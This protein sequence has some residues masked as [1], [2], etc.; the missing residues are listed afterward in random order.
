MLK[1][2]QRRTARTDSSRNFDA[3][4]KYYGISVLSKLVP[5]V[6]IYAGHHRWNWETWN[7]FSP[8]QDFRL[9]F[10]RPIFKGLFQVTPG[11]HRSSKEPPWIA[12]RCFFITVFFSNNQQCTNTKENSLQYQML[13]KDS[14]ENK[15]VY[16]VTLGQLQRARQPDSRLH[17][18]KIRAVYAMGFQERINRYAHH[19]ICAED[20]GFC[21]PNRS[22]TAINQFTPGSLIPQ[23]C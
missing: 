23:F 10:N 21:R 11:P 17:I 12:S 7:E 5:I 6:V 13:N 20:C 4:G 14:L 9:L 15:P 2:V 1:I 19:Y 18:N 3:Y 8:V 16:M 22:T